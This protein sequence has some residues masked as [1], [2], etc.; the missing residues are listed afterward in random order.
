MKSYFFDGLKKKLDFGS[1]SSTDQTKWIQTNITHFFNVFKILDAIIIFYAGSHSLKYEQSSVTN[2]LFE[3][4][5]FL[6]VSN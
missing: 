5:T 4:Y 6:I 3:I 1:S 2:V